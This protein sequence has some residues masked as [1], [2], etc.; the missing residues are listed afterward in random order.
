MEQ[1]EE[2]AF[3][4][5]SAFINKSLTGKS[6]LRLY[7]EVLGV[8]LYAFNFQYYTTLF[9]KLRLVSDER[10]NMVVARQAV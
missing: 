7:F 10:Q 2:M 8:Q 5:F 1:T 3:G 9:N 4:Q 6:F